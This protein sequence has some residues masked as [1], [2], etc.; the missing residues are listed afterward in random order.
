MHKSIERKAGI[1]RPSSSLRP[2]PLFRSIGPPGPS[3]SLPPHRR[4]RSMFCRSGAVLPANTHPTEASDTH[5]FTDIQSG[6]HAH[7]S[8]CPL[9]CNDALQP[10]MDS[11]LRRRA[12]FR[13][14][15]FADTWSVVSACPQTQSG[16]QDRQLFSHLCPSAGANGRNR[17]RQGRLVTPLQTSE[18]PA[19]KDKR[20]QKRRKRSYKVDCAGKQKYVV[21]SL[22]DKEREGARL[23]EWLQSLAIADSNEKDSVTTKQRRFVSR[24]RGVTGHGQQDTAASHRRDRRPHFLPPICQSDSLLHVSLLLLPEKSPPPSACTYPDAPIPSLPVPLL[25]PLSSR[26]K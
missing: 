19:I 14:G 5:T 18:A 15:V 16:Q 4:L 11:D 26:R 2:P 25:Q 24:C 12:A 21:A 3:A 6:N 20:Q 8:T 13:S 1:S 10:E 7:T 17:G 22:T 23:C 9:G